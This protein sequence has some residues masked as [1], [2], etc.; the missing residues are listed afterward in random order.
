MKTTI[1]TFKVWASE[2]HF[3]FSQNIEPKQLNEGHKKVRKWIEENLKGYK[4]LNSSDTLRGKRAKEK[5]VLKAWQWNGS[6]ADP[7]RKVIAV[8]YK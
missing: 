6:W 8:F 2:T 7:S 1:K 5:V 3:L 4:R